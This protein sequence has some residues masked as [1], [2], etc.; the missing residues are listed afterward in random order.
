MII[1]L[2]TH[3]NPVLNRAETARFLRRNGTDSAAL[4]MRCWSATS[5]TWQKFVSEARACDLTIMPGTELHAYFGEPDQVSFLL[6]NC[7]LEHPGLVDFLGA[8]PENL[9]FY[10]KMAKRQ[11][12][13][14]IAENGGGF[15][16]LAVKSDKR[17]SGVLS[18][19]GLDN[20]INA[21]MEL[22]RLFV[23][24]TN[25]ARI[26][27]ILEGAAAEG[28]LNEWRFMPA[29]C[30]LAYVYRDRL[31]SPLEMAAIVKYLYMHFN[32]KGKE[33][34]ADALVRRYTPEEIAE[35][36]HEAGG[37]LLLSL[38]AP[39]DRKHL[40]QYG[41]LVD[42]AC[43]VS[44]RQTF[45]LHPERRVEIVPEALLDRLASNGKVVVAGSDWDCYN[46]APGITVDS[47]GFPSYVK[48]SC[49]R[50]LTATK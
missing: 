15:Q 34:F 5:S 17:V 18:L 32:R 1:D 43:V 47:E 26:R 9:D 46:R 11:Y 6:L 13:Y 22:L 4:L 44:V 8:S 31:P 23:D 21:P 36:C 29:Q 39:G 16:P 7:D 30:F 50:L 10:R 14:L 38:E 35:V 25:L 24:S 42:G 40:E 37:T 19:E 48:E 20:P 2:H 27:A 45:N 3:P 41:D 33:G 12:D 49:E 28:Q